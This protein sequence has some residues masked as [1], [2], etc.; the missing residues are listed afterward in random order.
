MFYKKYF[1]NIKNV[2]NTESYE[3]YYHLLCV[4][5]MFFFAYKYIYIDNRY[6]DWSLTSMFKNLDHAVY[7]LQ[8]AFFTKAPLY[9]LL[10]IFIKYDFSKCII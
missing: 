6:T 7:Y 5:P 1:L 8:F 10:N 4:L 3:N 2:L 9:K